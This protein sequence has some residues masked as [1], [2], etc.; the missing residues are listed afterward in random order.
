M[1]KGNKHELNKSS[2]SSW[3]TPLTV[4]VSIITLIAIL[5]FTVFPKIG[6]W[7][8]K[9]WSNLQDSIQEYKDKEAG[10]IRISTVEEF[11][12]MHKS[13]NVVLE[14][15]LDFAGVT[16]SRADSSFVGIFDGNG[17]TIKNFTSTGTNASLF[18]VVSGAT[19]KNLKIE[20]IN[21]S[22]TYVGAIAGKFGTSTNT[23]TNVEV[24]S[25]TIGDD[26]SKYVGGIV[27]YIPSITGVQTNLVNKANVEGESWVG[28]ICGWYHYSNENADL[29]ATIM[30]WKNYGNVTGYKRN[31]DDNAS[32][33]VGGIFGAI[34][35]LNCGVV[36]N[37]CENYGNVT[38]K[39]NDYTAGIVGN[40]YYKPN[41]IFTVASNN[42][43]QFLNCKNEGNI[44][45]RT[46]VGG[47][48]GQVGDNYKSATFKDCSNKGSVNG[49]SSYVGGICGR[50]YD[51]GINATYTNC[52]NSGMLSKIS[53]A[54]YVGGIAGCYGTFKNCTNEM[55]VTLQQHYLIDVAMSYAGGIVGWANG[56]ISDCTNS[57]VIAGVQSE[58]LIYR[59]IGGIAGY[60]QGIVK[61]CSNTGTVKGNFGVG[62]IAGYLYVYQQYN[63]VYENNTSNCKLYAWGTQTTG[64]Q[65]YPFDMDT[66]SY[67]AVGGL[68]GLVDIEFGVR[69]NAVIK[70]C[71]VTNLNLTVDGYSRGIGGIV[72][73][74][75]VE[76]NE[77][78]D[79]YKISFEG[80]TAVAGII[81]TDSAFDGNIAKGPVLGDVNISALIQYVV[82]L[83]DSEFENITYNVVD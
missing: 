20:N 42:T 75:H 32:G 39:N 60:A 83:G 61:N 76:E 48:V 55:A 58:L 57:G 14:S 25:G 27:G 8:K 44:S 77:D 69:S 6:N 28:G 13:D 34:T 11:I 17:H 49:K 72:G 1:K 74:L 36:L 45:G 35:T 47:I 4:I 82:D 18:G 19:I 2:F 29:P 65:T 80:T 31:N 15:D 7:F 37:S 16:L 68:F 67:G 33:N 81:T 78:E 62:G 5:C 30:G 66:A 10:I 38:C 3:F 56:E 52:T 40:V 54:N 53:G 71:T 41:S 21:V 51:T 46:Y 22:G 63:N 50:T 9:G 79:A 59:Y 70:N 43:I 23:I 12:A 64:T 24:L 26:Q 73:M